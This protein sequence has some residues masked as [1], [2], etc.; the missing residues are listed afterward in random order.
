MSVGKLIASNKKARF[1]Y[2]IEETYEAGIVLKGTE[3]KSIRAGQVNIKEAYAEIKDG[4]V[5][6]HGMHIAPYEMGNVQNV[7]SLRVR[8]LLL[9]NREINKLIGYTNQKGYTLVPLRIYINPKG[10]IKIEIGVGKGK[11]LYDK[12]DS[13]AKR[14]SDRKIQQA[15]KMRN[16]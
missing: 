8:K 3:V 1:E 12:R 16:R 11:K 5:F 2:F 7:D 4:E 13:I 14:D 6:I 10:L 15:V 9:H